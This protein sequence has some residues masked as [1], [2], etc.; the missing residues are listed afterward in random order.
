MSMRTT[1]SGLAIALRALQA[2]QISLDITGH[3]VANAN[4]PNYSRQT[5]LH[6]ATKPYPAPMMGYTPSSGQ[7]GTGVEISQIN[8]MRDGFVD[9]R[10]RQQLHSKNYWAAMEDGLRQVELF[11]NEPSENGI[12]YALDQFWDSLQDL[13]REPDFIAVREVVVQ[14]A[15]VLVESIRGTR[16]NLQSLRENINGNIPLKVDEVNSLARRIA[17]LNVEIGKITATGSIPNDLLD[18]RDGLVEELSH[19]VDIEVVQD[20]AGMIGVTIGGASLVHRGTS[21]GLT[22]TVGDESD[23]YRKVEVIWAATGNKADIR[24]G[25]IGG[26]L[27]LREEITRVIGEL[28][29]WTLDFALE[30]NRRHAVG[31]DAKGNGGYT[32]TIDAENP[33]EE[34]VPNDPLF[35]FFVFDNLD[36][37][38][39]L[40]ESLPY[41]ALNI[42]VNKEIIND[43]GLIRAGLQPA[44]GN[45]ENALRLASLRF[46]PIE[47]LSKKITGGGDQDVT[48]GDSFNQIIADLGVKTQRAGRLNENDTNL[49]L[50]LRNLKDSISGVSLDEEM[51]NMI[52]F[53]HAYSAAARVMTAMD[54][55]LDTIINR[56]GIVGR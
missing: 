50:H 13:S 7:L 5:A 1:F 6:S 21:Y 54:E 12:H 18:A 15:H 52:R 16:E 37:G 32:G 48:I 43:A 4:N 24:S 55:A 51:A 14:R 10:L 27:D 49:E 35:Y 26:L 11:F 9:L 8:R 40:D 25:E 3:N 53:Q 17:D 29:D 38:A 56:L 44:A 39:T 20:Y 36:K 31:Y 46:T 33:A 41:A 22:T 34:A 2:Q 47:R 28:D 45:G 30:F 19:L 23:N 42:G